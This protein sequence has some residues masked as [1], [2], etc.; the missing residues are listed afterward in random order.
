MS[1][2]FSDS[3]CA[4]RFA[5]RKNAMAV[6]R[7]PPN[8]IISPWKSGSRTRGSREVQYRQ[9]QAI[10]SKGSYTAMAPDRRIGAPN[11]GENRNSFAMYSVAIKL[12]SVISRNPR[13]VDRQSYEPRN[14]GSFGRRYIVVCLSMRLPPIRIFLDVSRLS[15]LHGLSCAAL[16]HLANSRMRVAIGDR[17]LLSRARLPVE[18]I[19]WMRYC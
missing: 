8:A 12:D 18:E 3:F 1:S 19:L 16:A 15:P 9:P 6:N 10:Q 13:I 14:P 17:Q 7:E 2:A 5:K 11:A 4:R